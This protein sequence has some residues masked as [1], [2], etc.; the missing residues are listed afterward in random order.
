MTV[1][2]LI[3]G[4]SG[5][6][7]MILAARAF[8]AQVALTEEF[9]AYWGLFFAGTGVLTG[10]NQEVTRAVSAHT[11]GTGARPIKIGGFIGVIT[12][13]VMGLSALW[14]APSILSE[15]YLPGAAL[16]SLGLGSYA[17]QATLAGILAGR[18]QWAHL[19]ALITL[20]TASRMVLAVLAWLAGW[21]LLAF[22]II[23]VL[24]ALSWVVILAGSAAARAGLRATADVDTGEFVRRAGTAMVAAGA[25][26]VLI[27]G[28][29][30]LVRMTHPEAGAGD[31]ATA[32]AVIYAVT[33][34]R[35]PLLLPLQQF[36]PTL[37]VGFVQGKTLWRPLAL[38][39]AVG[40]VG[41]G[42]AW[43]IGPW[44]MLTI[45]NNEAYSTPGWLLAA[46]TLG[47]ACTASL[48]VSGAA[49][50]AKE[51]HT[52]YLVGWLVATA[53]AIGFLAAPLPLSVGAVLAL[54]V[55]P[56][57][58]LCTHFLGL[59]LLKLQL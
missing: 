50:M 18:E 16:M 1:A 46:L 36:L 32:A 38:I 43:A 24:G 48:M 12:A 28:F 21:Q 52:L 44:L 34:T 35:A 30:T 19:A 26:A 7:V 37:I 22:L 15:H 14:W 13:L 9:T 51:L 27:V 3:A 55:G 54:S 47:A 17:I 39:W 42:G 4:V 2:T 31:V 33:F 5:F 56:L 23:T 53:V 45:L 41:A 29:P 59:T 49:T 40:L 57:V 58:G 20:D 6:V 10:L 8:G 25:T 11:G